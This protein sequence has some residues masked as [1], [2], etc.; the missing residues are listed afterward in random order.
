M[1]EEKKPSPIYAEH[2]SSRNARKGGEGKLFLYKEREREIFGIY[3]YI[4]EKSTNGNPGT[5]L[6]RIPQSRVQSGIE[7]IPRDRGEPTYC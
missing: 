4:P 5:A 3:I 6:P 7:E 1:W 2:V